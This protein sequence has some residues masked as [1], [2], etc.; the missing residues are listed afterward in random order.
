MSLHYLEEKI[1]LDKKLFR[2]CR[3]SVGVPYT[4]RVEC[5]EENFYSSIDLGKFDG[6]IL[7]RRFRI[8]EPFFSS[9][10]FYKNS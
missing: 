7:V 1:L 5:E 2:V 3:L 6:I 4:L 8:K 10:C 9:C